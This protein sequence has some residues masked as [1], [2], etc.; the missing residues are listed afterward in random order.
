LLLK[1]SDWHAPFPFPSEVSVISGDS[2]GG[3]DSEGPLILIAND[4]EWAA[5]S[6]ESLLVSE[7][8]RVIRAYT[9]GQTLDRLTQSA[10]D[11]VVLDVQMPDIDGFEVCRRLRAD[12]RFDATLPVMITTAGP[13]GRS[14]RLEA[15]RAGAWAFH[16]QPL[17]SEVLIGEVQSFVAAKGAADQIREAS[18]LD[19]E[20]GLYNRRGLAQRAREL[21]SEA[22]RY[23]APLAC[24]VIAPDVAN[25]SR[26][27]AIGDVKPAL[28]I[29]GNGETSA[30]ARRLGAMFRSS[31][32]TA[33]AIGR[34][35]RLEFAIMAPKTGAAGVEAL[36]LRFESLLQVGQADGLAAVPRLR[37]GYWASDNIAVETL[38]AEEMV[39]RASAALA[40]ARDDGRIRA[41]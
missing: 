36:V 13:A 3:G 28:K 26:G 27:N 25:G 7:G 8:Y 1:C 2:V 16:G 37:A 20:T 24:V 21:C 15:F 41:A 12:P 33:D 10:P 22:H 4:Q 17:D 6:L 40:L 18:M 38:D 30:L 35:G 32:R 9:G 39:A 11:L 19:P 34:I 5:R 14:Q 29:N 23:R 31:G